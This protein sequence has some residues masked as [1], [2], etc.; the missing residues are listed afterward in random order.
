MI[1]KDININIYNVKK[2]V[3][4]QIYLFDKNDPIEIKK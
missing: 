4:L 1:I 3:K 2:Y